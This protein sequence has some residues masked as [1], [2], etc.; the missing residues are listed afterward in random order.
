MP[1]PEDK[2]RQQLQIFDSIG[3]VSTMSCEEVLCT[4]SDPQISSQ[5][6]NLASAFIKVDQL[7]K[8][9]KIG[10]IQ[11]VV[12]GRSTLPE[13]A[14]ADDES[15]RTPKRNSSRRNESTEDEEDEDEEEEEMDGS[16]DNTN[17]SNSRSRSKHAKNKSINRLPTL[18]DSSTSL[19]QP[20]DAKPAEYVVQSKVTGSL[21][22]NPENAQRNQRGYNFMMGIDIEESGLQDD[23]DAL[24]TTTFASSLTSALMGSKAMVETTRQVLS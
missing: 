8:I 1:S 3:Q 9:L 10:P 6:T 14:M 5:A 18:S 20:D 4:G 15:N 7:A 13:P 2:L 22:S 11:N 12:I 24:I 19:S 17:N 23:N 16:N 21:S